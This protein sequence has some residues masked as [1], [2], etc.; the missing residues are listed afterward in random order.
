MDWSPY[1]GI[2][3]S[4]D[5][6]FK[7]QVS[8]PDEFEFS[9]EFFNS[10]DIEF[11]PTDSTTL[12]DFF[13]SSDVDLIDHKTSVLGTIESSSVDSSLTTP[14]VEYSKV[15]CVSAKVTCVIY[16]LLNMIG[17]C[18]F[19]SFLWRCCYVFLIDPWL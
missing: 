3:E 18:I 13:F 6:P 7:Q 5:S 2:F 14:Y 17:L 10:Y 8:D 16:F 12:V 19:L 9:Y 11:V 15:A 4:L 1:V